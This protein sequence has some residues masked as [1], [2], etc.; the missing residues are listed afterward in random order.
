[1]EANLALFLVVLGVTLFLYGLSKPPLLLLSW[2]PFVA[3]LYTYNSARVVVPLL[4]LLL[5]VVYRHQLLAV[6]RYVLLTVILVVLFSF[7]AYQL[8][9]KQDSSARYRWTAILDEGAINSINE[10]RRTSTHSPLVSQLLYNK[11]TFA[12]PRIIGGYLSHF[13]PDFLFLQGS[14]NYQFNTPGVGL[15]YPVEFPLLLLGLFAIIRY[16]TPGGILIIGWLLVSPLAAAI[17][18]DAPHALRTILM[19]PTPQIISALGLGWFLEK[20]KGPILQK[21]F[22]V[23]MIVFLFMNVLSYWQQYNTTYRQTYS[24]SWQYGY[25][26]AIEYVLA[27]QQNYKTI[28]FTK[29]YG[30]PHI[31]LLFFGKFSPVQ[32][33]ENPTLTRYFRTDWYWVDGFDQYKFL[34]DWEVAEK[35]K[36]YQ[37]LTDKKR[38]MLVASP[39]NFPRDAKILQEIYFLDGKKAF[40]IVEL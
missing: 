3:S 21:T 10:A 23:G 1:M 25:K 27:H 7:P 36:E 28:L 2:L 24:W 20:M 29:K 15:M 35:G 17:T 8:A 19:L 6:K 9:I 14:S 4:L 5:L 12:L 26:Q 33:Q 38:T 11:A 16:K 40:D 31:F 22:A 39:G 18:R 13:S 34:N 32:Y 37:R 30:E